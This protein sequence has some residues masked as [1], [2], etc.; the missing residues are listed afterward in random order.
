MGRHNAHHANPDHEDR[1]PD[2][3]LGVLAFTAGQARG[4]R[5]LGRFFTAH[6]NP[7]LLFFPLL[8]LEGLDLHDA[9]AEPAPS[10][11]PRPAWLVLT[12]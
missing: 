11:T 8:L 5:A 3:Q 4:R 2:V 9:T 1:D 10:P 7:A 6:P 12:P